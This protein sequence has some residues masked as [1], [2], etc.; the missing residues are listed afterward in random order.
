MAW[1]ELSD[2]RC[3]YETLGEGEPLLL[4]PGLGG[5][6][7]VF[8]PIVPHLA[9]QFS[10]ILIDNRGIGRSVQKRKPRTLA[11]YS[12]DIVQLLD[13]LQL[14]RA[15]VLGLSLGGIIAQRFAIDHPSRVD[16]LVLVSC[17]DRFS[18]YLLRVTQLL[19]HSLRRFPRRVFLNMME[20]LCT[21]PLYLDANVDAIDREADDRCKAGV[22]ARAMGTQLRALLRS[23]VAPADY[24]IHAPT[25]VVAGEHDHLIPNC[26]ARIMA[27]K[28]PGSRFVL[29]PGAGHNPMVELPDTVLPLIARF[30]RTGE[31]YEPPDELEM[32]HDTEASEAPVLVDRLA[33]LPPE[34]RPR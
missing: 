10:L 17:A 15:H 14:D 22:P 7:R 1:A 5:H 25:L 23:E 19:G 31:P 3:Y 27:A 9:S 11:D 8:D 24:R 26:Y 20:V 4:I 16:R 34:G 29:V 12:A 18:Q 6:C 33:A 21:A 13:H 2:V 30:L 28:I 32:N